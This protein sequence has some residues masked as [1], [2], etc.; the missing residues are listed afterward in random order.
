MS[1]GSIQ[2]DVKLDTAGFANDLKS[3]TAGSID[4]LKE[5]DEAINSNAESGLKKL[6]GVASD[7][8]MKLIDFS[9]EEK[10]FLTNSSESIIKAEHEKQNQLKQLRKN[11]SSEELKRLEEEE[12]IRQEIT[13]HEYTQLKNQLELGLISQEEYYLKLREFRDKY[14]ETGT[15]GWEKYTVEILKFCKDTSE[16]IAETQKNAILN[17]FD[18]MSKKTDESSE[19]LLKT[20]AKMENK[21]KDYGNLYNKKSFTSA[22]SGNTY[23]W[24][25]LADIENDLTV[26]TNYNNA[27][28]NTKDLLYKAFPIS[29]KNISE[30]TAAA[31]K[32]Y[33]KAFFSQISD[34][35][36][37]EGLTFSEFLTRLPEKKVTEYLTAWSEKQNLAKEISKNLYSDEAMDIY[38]TNIKNMASNMISILEENFGNLP[39]NFF[40]EGVASA[41]GFGDGFISSINAVFNN[42]R[43][44]IDNEFLRLMPNSADLTA[45]N[46]TVIENSTSYNIYGGSSPKSTALEIYKYDQLKRMLVGEYK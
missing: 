9:E 19:T 27:L 1:D 35:S 18:E 43:S 33:I 24:L 12:N 8:F 31:N 17:V 39:E 46:N 13:E 10:N 36:V 20:Q 7:S 28:K 23:S 5:L 38:N 40:E 30:E 16:S 42:I 3:L 6:E 32:E 34:M 21:L 4:T 44:Q 11:A 15:S 22:S 2:F 14:F 26:L 45:Q 37:E 41:L 25:A 29:G